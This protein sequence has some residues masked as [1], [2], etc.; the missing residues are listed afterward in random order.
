[1]KK[2][3]IND[4]I[5][6]CRKYKPQGGRILVHAL[7]IR[8]VKQSDYGFDLADTKANEGKNPAIHRVDLKKVQP[9]INAKYQEAVILQV[10]I[11]EPTLKVG[12]T[13]VYPFGCT[14][15]FD[16]VKGVSTMKI[17]DVVAIVTDFIVSDSIDRAPTDVERSIVQE[18]NLIGS[19]MM[20][21][22]TI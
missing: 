15:D 6:E 9:K 17:W 5:N 4:L 7:K 3:D 14:N 10:P 13:I 1:M 19:A 22:Y 8:Q 2:F 18:H 20:G 11:D 21:G 16:L 12:N